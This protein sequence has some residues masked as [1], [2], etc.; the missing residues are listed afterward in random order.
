MST[1]SAHTWYPII[2]I[3]VPLS[4]FVGRVFV[5]IWVFTY[6][7]ICLCCMCLYISIFLCL[8]QHLLHT[9][10]NPIIPIILLIIF[11]DLYLCICW[12]SH[13]YIFVFPIIPIIFLP[14]PDLLAVYLCICRRHQPSHLVA[15]TARNILRSICKGKKYQVF[16]CVRNIK[17][18]MCWGS[19]SSFGGV[20]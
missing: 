11:L 20:L 12:F 7:C 9:L 6:L 8:G 18:N 3:T 16:S 17:W 13:L 5:C 2:P 1:L 15:A 10:W 4:R 19:N 14:L